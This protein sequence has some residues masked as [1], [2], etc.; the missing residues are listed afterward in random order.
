MWTQCVCGLQSPVPRLTNKEI[1]PNNDAERV[2]GFSWMLSHSRK[3]F[4]TVHLQ[5]CEEVLTKLEPDH[6]AAQQRSC[7]AGPQSSPRPKASSASRDSRTQREGAHH[8]MVLL[9]SILS[10]QL[11]KAR[12]F[13]V[14]TIM[15]DF[16][17]I[18]LTKFSGFFPPDLLL[19]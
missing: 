19:K 4:W 9:T 2:L 6:Q 18:L 13:M 16:L 5:S 8:G 15:N 7:R 14:A 12:G 17:W 1:P 10:F 11:R 3:Q